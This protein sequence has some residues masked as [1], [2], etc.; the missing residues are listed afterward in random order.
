MKRTGFPC[1]QIM[2]AALLLA[3]IVPALHPQSN[4]DATKPYAWGENIGWCDF[5][6]DGTNGVV[7]TADYLRGY[8]WLENV[9]W[10]YLGSI[11]NDGIAYTQNAGDTGINNDGS[12][13]LSGYAWGEN[14][15]WVVFNPSG[16]EQQVIIESDGQFSGYA[17]GENIGWIAM[18]SGHGVISTV[19]FPPAGVFDWKLIK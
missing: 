2:I 5:Y 15:G 1:G 9:G 13:N 19:T 18:N 11:P 17:W 14:I 7:I 8:V 12:G 10:L 4:I 3:T 16:S 6:V